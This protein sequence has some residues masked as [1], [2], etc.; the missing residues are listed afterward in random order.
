MRNVV[1]LPHTCCEGKEKSEELLDAVADLLRVEGEL[2]LSIS[3]KG[4][5]DMTVVDIGVLWVV[6]EV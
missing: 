2:K 3:A 1:G 5:P 6:D 4:K